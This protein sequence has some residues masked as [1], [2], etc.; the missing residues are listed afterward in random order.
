ML[1]IAICDDEQFYRKKIQNLL[2]GYLGRRELQYELHLFLSG[3]EFLRQCENSVKFDIV[4]LDINMDK[5]D[6]IQT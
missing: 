1:Q 2:E 5:I 4:F 6:G 3:E